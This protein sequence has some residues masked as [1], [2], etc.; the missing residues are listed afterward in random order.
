MSVQ[1]SVLAMVGEL[2]SDVAK[3]LYSIAY[4]FVLAF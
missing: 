3:L 4:V 2:G 1:V